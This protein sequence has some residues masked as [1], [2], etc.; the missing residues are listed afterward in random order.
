MQTKQTMQ[1]MQT[2]E[3]KQQGHQ[4]V[5]ATMGAP[6]I[7]KRGAH[8]LK[9]GYIGLLLDGSPVDQRGNTRDTLWE[10]VSV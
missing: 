3:Q 6:A 8:P 7:P 2:Q 4:P 5:E 9:C 1:T 10:S